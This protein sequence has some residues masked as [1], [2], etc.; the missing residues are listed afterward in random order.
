M[1][2]LFKIKWLFLILFLSFSLNLY[3]DKINSYSVLSDN[4]KLTNDLFIDKI[5][6]II[7]TQPEFRQAIAVKGEFVENRKFASRQR[8]PSL[9]AQIINDRTISRDIESGNRLR[10]TQ[11]DAFDAQVILDQPIYTGNEINSKVK[12]AKLEISRASIELSKTASELI[13]SASEIYINAASTKI[14]SDYCKNLFNDLKR[15]RDIVKRRFDGGII[16]G[17]EMAIVNV[18]L[19]EIEAKL[20]RLEANEIKASSIYRSF[21]KEEYDGSGPP[22]LELININDLSM[23]LENIKTYDELVAKNTIENKTAD[24]ELTKSQY[25]PKFGFNARYTQYDVDEDAEDSDIRGGIY[26]NFPLFNFGRG[27]AEVGA[28]KARINQAKIN[29]EKSKRD[30][31]TQVASVIGSATGTLQARNRLKDSYINIKLQRE[32]YFNSISSS[33]F[34]ISALLEAALRELNLFEQ[35]I[36]N[37]NELLISDLQSSHLNRS[38]LNRFKISY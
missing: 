37:E 31:E 29:S 26:F 34:S 24:L 1:F 23:Y 3:A 32:T 2:H 15:Y 35:L 36:N 13:L 27:S 20:A 8:F 33:Q 16:S 6:S 4:S 22:S 11:D 7:I 5:Q 18:R 28:S 21:F 38:L 14:L 10:K 17:S 25:R 9:T 19:S 30:K 12:I